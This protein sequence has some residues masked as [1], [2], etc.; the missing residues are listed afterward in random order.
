M[1]RDLDELLKDLIEA[2]KE[3]EAKTRE[4]GIEKLVDKANGQHLEK[5]DNNQK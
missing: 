2:E 1:A 5:T 3:F 4:Y